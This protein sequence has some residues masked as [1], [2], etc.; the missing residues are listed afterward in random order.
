MCQEDST[1]SSHAPVQCAVDYNIG[2]VIRCHYTVT[3]LWIGVQSAHL[4]RR[5]ES[6]FEDHG[7]HLHHRRADLPFVVEVAAE[8]LIGIRLCN[9]AVDTGEVEERKVCSECACVA[10]CSAE[11]HRDSWSPISARVSESLS[12][13]SA[14]GAEQSVATTTTTQVSCNNNNNSV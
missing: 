13:A 12:E 3:C 9:A 4:G 10:V 5:D 7:D 2:T 8:N 14:A 6:Q 11:T 1:H